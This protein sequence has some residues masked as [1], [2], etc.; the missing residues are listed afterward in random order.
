MPQ[1]TPTDLLDKKTIKGKSAALS[2]I[3]RSQHVRIPADMRIPEDVERVKISQRGNCFLIHPLE[4]Y[5]DYFVSLECI[6]TNFL[7]RHPLARY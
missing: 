3:G 6:Q 1:K 5:T 7:S 4:A 2:I